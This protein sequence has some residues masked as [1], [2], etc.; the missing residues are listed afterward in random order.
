MSECNQ[1]GGDGY[2]NKFQNKDGSTTFEMCPCS[3]ITAES[4]KE[5]A[6]RI[7]ITGEECVSIHPNAA[8][9]EK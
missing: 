9:E 7:K 5:L 4:V 3:G 2:L 1:C 8:E 6:D